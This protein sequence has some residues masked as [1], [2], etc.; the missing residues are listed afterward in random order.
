MILYIENPKDTTRI[1]L[2]LISDNSK[3][4]RY[5]ISTQKLFAFLY[6]DQE[7]TART[8]HGPTDWF[9]IGKEYVK[10]VYCYPAYL[11]YTQSTS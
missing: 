3:V 5:K 8:G 9:Q 1:L 10:V 7:A 4:E 2:V 11:T 6:A